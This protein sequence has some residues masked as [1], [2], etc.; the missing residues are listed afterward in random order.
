VKREKK[1]A[2]MPAFRTTVGFVEEPELG[3]K[4]MVITVRKDNDIV[5]HL[6]VG[7]ASLHWF[8][9]NAKKKGNKVSWDD[10]IDFL[11]EKPVVKVT[12]P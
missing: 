10:F 5:G 1:G 6:M 2:S 4:G 9:K 3:N 11:R 8:D 7:K 12:R